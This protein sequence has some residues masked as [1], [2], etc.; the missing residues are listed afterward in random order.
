MLCYVWLFLV[1]L[2]SWASILQID[3]TE[4]IIFERS[5]TSTTAHTVPMI[6]ERAKLNYKTPGEIEKP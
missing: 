4:N 6:E 3:V 1:G 2:V 5:S